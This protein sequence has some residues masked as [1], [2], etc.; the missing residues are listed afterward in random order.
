M[1]EAITKLREEKNTST[2]ARVSVLENQVV[3]IS[4]S[5]E[6]LEM[7][8]EDQYKTLHSRISDLRDDVR[9]DIDQK[10][11][12]LIQKIDEHS[13]SSSLKLDHIENKISAIEKWRWMIMGAAI[14][15]GYV[16]A[17]IKLENLF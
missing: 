1:A 2:A 5:I 13:V 15:I 3:N 8:V 14:V 9:G 17:H 11:E 6:K 12:K 7:R 10:N 16:L 4:H